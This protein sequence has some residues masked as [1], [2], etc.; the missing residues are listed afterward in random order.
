MSVEL[1]PPMRAKGM[2][3]KLIADTAKGIAA[4]EWEKLSTNSNAFHKK[5][6]KVKPFVGHNWRLYVPT[7][8]ALL[9]GMLGSPSVAPEMKER[10]HGAILLDGAIN[11]KRMAVPEKPSYFLGPT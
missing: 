8:R 9:V 11:P 6:P 4:E 7:A 2:V 3:H 1:A 5:W 10:I